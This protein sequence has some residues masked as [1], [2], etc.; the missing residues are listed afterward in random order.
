[1]PTLGGTLTGI[2]NGD[3][4]T[5]SYYTPATATSDAGSYPITPTLID[6]SGR[7]AN[8]T[9]TATGGMI[10]ITPIAPTVN[11]S[12][13][14]GTYTGLPCVASGA[15][16]GLNGIYLCAPSFSYYN[17]SSATGT[18]LSSPP[19]NAGTYTVL[20]SYA[21]SL[22]YTAGSNAVTFTVGQAATTVALPTAPTNIVAN[23]IGSVTSWVAATVTGVSGAPAPTG[24]VTY[25]YYVGSSA[26]GTPLSS[27]PIAAG[28]Y[29]VVANYGGNSNYL[30]SQSSP[31]S[32]TIQPL[33]ASPVSVSSFQV[34]DG[35]V[36][37][38]MVDSLTVTFNTS[39]TLAAG[40]VSLW[41]QTTNTAIAV[42]C[43][44]LAGSTT[45][46][47]VT[48]SGNQIVGGSLANGRYVL[49]VNAGGVNSSGG[50][51][52]ASQSY[53]FLRLFGDY[54]GDGAVNNTDYLMFKKANGA[55]AGSSSPTNATYDTYWYFD[56]YFNNFASGSSINSNDLSKFLAD[57][58]TSI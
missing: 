40:A 45:S 46:Y 37:R 1:M 4:I 36:Q 48:W 28:T 9:V 49:T 16:T 29:T 30:P 24:G 39:V 12:H 43:T 6:P 17:G 33:P 18:P 2:V 27:S 57:Y 3:A 42:N 50:A 31:V 53:S 21:A 19:V 23:G 47:L 55:V 41:D 11:V 32:F 7:L 51:M 35:N 10:T 14:G 5:T 22:D 54:H 25:T 13:S 26:A 34:N 56:Y 44:A 38:S 8:Y 52:A 58:G 15:V 20:A